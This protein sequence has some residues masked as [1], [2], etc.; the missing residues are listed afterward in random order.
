[1]QSLA[2]IFLGI[3]VIGKSSLAIR[4]LKVLG[5]AFFPI[6]VHSPNDPSLKGIKMIH[7]LCQAGHL[8]LH[9]DNGIRRQVHY[10]F[11]FRTGAASTRFPIGSQIILPQRNSCKASRTAELL[12]DLQY[13]PAKLYMHAAAMVETLSR[14]FAWQTLSTSRCKGGMCRNK[15]PLSNC[16]SLTCLFVV[17]S[18]WKDPD[19]TSQNA[20]NTAP[21]S[22]HR[23]PSGSELATNH[24][25]LW[26][27]FT[28]MIGM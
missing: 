3:L 25:S 20:K 28:S 17:S 5:I 14:I 22:H 6:F 15:R 12:W 18:I 26:N 13:R 24:L 21:G 23:R 2:S 19:S 8:Y 4:T 27:F 16:Q 7:D 10:R 11:L 9:K 1:V